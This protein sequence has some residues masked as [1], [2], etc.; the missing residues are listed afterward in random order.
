MSLVRFFQI[1]SLVLTSHMVSVFAA[2]FIGNH[3]SLKVENDI[4]RN[5][6]HDIKGSPWP[7]E[8]EKAN[9]YCK[10]VARRFL[11]HPISKRIPRPSFYFVECSPPLDSGMM[12]HKCTFGSYTWR[13]KDKKRPA[14]IRKDLKEYVTDPIFWS[15]RG[16]ISGDG[17]IS[18]LVTQADLEVQEKIQMGK[19]WSNVAMYATIGYR[20]AMEDRFMV[21]ENAAGTQASF[22]A[23]FDGHYG[24]DAVRYARD[25]LM[26]IIINEIAAVRRSIDLKQASRSRNG[27]KS[28]FRFKVPLRKT[29]TRSS[30]RRNSF[31][32]KVKTESKC[33]TKSFI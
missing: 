8:I 12:E 25:V 3:G 31:P 2:E 20:D 15:H 22:Y 19:R 14:V 17:D 32:P 30:K 16:F 28:R 29:R 21:Y 13:H 27:S 1:I 9:E 23:V 10:N 26:K 24:E 11:S 6:C 18:T 4:E 33:K 5:I 7:E